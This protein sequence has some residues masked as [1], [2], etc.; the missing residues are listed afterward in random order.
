MKDQDGTGDSSSSD[1]TVPHHSRPGQGRLL[2]NIK[3]RDFMVNKKRKAAD[4]PALHLSKFQ[5]SIK[6]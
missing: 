6:A 5:G 2:Q 3:E 1:W 4:V